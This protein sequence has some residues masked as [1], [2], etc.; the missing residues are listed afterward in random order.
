MVA[1][2][3]HAASRVSTLRSVISRGPLGGERVLTD[4]L[5][6]GG[7]GILPTPAAGP[8][9]LAAPVFT[10]ARAASPRA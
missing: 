4:E 5:V 2:A 10:S 7:D 6:E 9:D 8:T 3:S 1:K